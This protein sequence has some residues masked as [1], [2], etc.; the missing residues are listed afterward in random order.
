MNVQMSFQF[1][2]EDN[3]IPLVK[4]QFQIRSQ[5]FSRVKVHRLFVDVIII[6][7]YNWHTDDVRWDTHSIKCYWNVI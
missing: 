2:S 1:T 6:I 5:N 7:N 4:V 3:F